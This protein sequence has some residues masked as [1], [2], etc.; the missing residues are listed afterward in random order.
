V[1]TI[2]YSRII[3]I[4]SALIWYK[5]VF[6]IV[7][8]ILGVLIFGYLSSLAS[9]VPIAISYLVV[10]YLLFGSAFVFEAAGIFL[11]VRRTANRPKN[12]P[13]IPD[14]DIRH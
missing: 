8:I 6:G 1:A 2:Q 9:T 12:K 13:L 3:E 7:L 14:A 4:L 11:V 10:N 5:I